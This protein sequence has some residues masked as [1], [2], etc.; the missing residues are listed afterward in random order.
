[1]GGPCFAFGRLLLVRNNAA[2]GWAQGCAVEV[3]GTVDLGP[4]GKF[5]IDLRT[6]EEVQSDLCLG[7]EMIPKMNWEVFIHAAEAGNKMIFEG[8]DGPFCSIAAMDAWW[9]K[10]IIDIIVVHEFFE[11]SRAFVVKT[12]QAGLQA[13]FA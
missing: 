8:T 5:G 3:K 2:S 12:L 9:Y 4:S 11:K 7:E 13:G 10:L 1:M 6:T